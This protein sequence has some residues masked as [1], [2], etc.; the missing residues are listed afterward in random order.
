MAN[1]NVRVRYRP[2][3][4]GWCI[5]DKNWDDFRRA[6][7]LTHVFLGW[8]VQ[9][10][11]SGWASS[12]QQ[13]VRRFRVDILV[14]IVDDSQI[15]AFLKSFSHLPWPVLLERGLFNAQPAPIF[16]DISHPLQRL[17]LDEPK[18]EGI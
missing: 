11:H 18:S 12:A 8:Q 6:L 16:L 3:R 5:R 13:L 17:A 1:V 10:H 9:S 14:D 15:E 7:R 4:I 2:I